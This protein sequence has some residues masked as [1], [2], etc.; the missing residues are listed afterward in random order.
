MGEEA[1][2]TTEPV[3]EETK[4]TETNEEQSGAKPAETETKTPT[5]QDLLVEVAKQKRTIDKLMTE[6]AEW[7]KKYQSTLS[8]KEKASQEKAEREAEK[9][10]QFKQLVR[11]NQMNKIEKSYLSRGWTADEANRMATAEVDNDFDARMKILS[12]VETRKAKEIKNEFLKSRPELQYGSDSS[13][14]QE[15]FDKMSLAERTKLHRER[16]ELY[17]QLVGRR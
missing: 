4:V 12:E 10:E 14:T 13:V 3:T 7:R 5:V 1:T 9:E 2:K 6:S 16:P 17:K 15:Q 11:E 8:E